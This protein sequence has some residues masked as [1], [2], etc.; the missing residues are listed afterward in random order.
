MRKGVLFLVGEMLLIFWIVMVSFI[1]SHWE[2]YN[3]G[4]LYLPWAYDLSQVVS[5]A[6]LLTTETMLQ[7]SVAIPN[8]FN[9]KKAYF[10][11]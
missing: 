3:T 11:A 1:M 9:V 5:A 6:L 8:V 2:K 7:K 4:V 10:V